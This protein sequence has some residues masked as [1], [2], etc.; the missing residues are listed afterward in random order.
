MAAALCAPAAMP[1]RMSKRMSHAPR[2]SI[3]MAGLAEDEQDNKTVYH[4][5]CKH[6]KTVV[7]I[8]MIFGTLLCIILIVVG[9]NSS[10]NIKHRNLPFCLGLLCVKIVYTPLIILVYM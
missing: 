10:F 2:L 9:E 1:G 6:I 7:T 3:V 4:F 8:V 5:C